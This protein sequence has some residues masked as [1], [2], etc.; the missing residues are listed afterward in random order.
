MHLLRTLAV[1]LTMVLLMVQKSGDHQ[2][3]LVVIPLIY[4]VLKAFH[5]VVWDLAG[6]LKHQYHN[7]LLC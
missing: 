7:Q 2:L 1:L 6:F 5:V 4:K 3:R